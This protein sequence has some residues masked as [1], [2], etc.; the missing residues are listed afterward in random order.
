MAVWPGQR[1]VV[2]ADL[3][4]MLLGLWLLRLELLR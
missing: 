4:Q 1:L 2:R 3:R